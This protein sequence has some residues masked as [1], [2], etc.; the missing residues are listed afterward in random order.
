MVAVDTN[1]LVRL[2]VRDD[3]A[4]TAA[5]TRFIENGCWSPI[6]AIAE[7]VWVL[8]SFYRFNRA[9]VLEALDMLLNNNKLV[10]D[11]SEAVTEAVLLLRA[12]PALG[13][14]DCLM[15][16]LARKAGHLPLGTFDRNL[17]K[18]PGATKL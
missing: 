12:R 13:F 6:L 1:V 5:A 7:T 16:E 3:P 10:I 8:Q 11:D 9:E 2:I 14:A 15:L 18:C 4:Q 17:A